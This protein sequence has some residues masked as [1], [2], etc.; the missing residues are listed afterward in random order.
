[1]FDRESILDETLL[2]FYPDSDDYESEE[3]CD[4]LGNSLIDNIFDQID[5][6]PTVPKRKER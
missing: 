1:M 6:A 3:D 5:A 2:D 4:S